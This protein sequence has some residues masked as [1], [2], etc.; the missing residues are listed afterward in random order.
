MGIKQEPV[1]EPTVG[2]SPAAGCRA[3][4][5]QGRRKARP[6]LGMWLPL[7]KPGEGAKRGI[8]QQLARSQRLNNYRNLG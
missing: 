2:L 7:A 5:V 1:A 8:E 3:T 6:F 4:C